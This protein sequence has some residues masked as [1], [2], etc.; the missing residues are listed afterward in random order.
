VARKKKTLNEKNSLRNNLRSWACEH[1]LN[2]AKGITE[3]AKL[4]PGLG[5]KQHLS[6]SFH[7]TPS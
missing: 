7:P 6:Q 3:M 5:R 4:C 2:I 1:G